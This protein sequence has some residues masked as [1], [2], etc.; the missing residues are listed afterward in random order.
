MTLENPYRAAGAFSGKAY[1][2]REA[3]AQLIEQI[4]DN[5]YYPYFA[6]PRQ[7]GKSSLLLRTMAALDP[8]KYRCALVDLSPFV[9]ASYDDFW[10]QFLHEVARSANFDPTPI[11]QEDPRDVLLLWLHG[12]KQ[13]LI[14][15]MD[16]IDVL[17]NVDFR[18]Q[19]FSKFRTFFNLR[20]RLDT[21]ELQ[22]L[23][24]VL[25]G[26]AHSSR[27][28]KDPRWSPFNVAIEIELEDLS[29]AQV[30]QLAAYLGTAGAFAGPDLTARVY[31]LSGGSVFL[32]QLIF[33]QLWNVAARTKGKLGA[34]DVDAV[35]QTIVAES[36]RNIHFYNIFRLVTADARLTMLFRRLTEGQE[37]GLEEAKELRLTGICRGANPFRNEIYARVFGPGGP[38]DLKVGDKQLQL[39][40]ALDGVL[41]RRDRLQNDP[42]ADPRALAAAEAEIRRLR[43]EFREGTQLQAGDVL[44]RGRYRLEERIGQGGFAAVWRAI[45]LRD[46][47]DP[48]PV[49]IK[50]LHGQFAEDKSRRERFFRGAWKMS[51]LQHPAIVRVIEPY[52]DENGQFYFV[53]EYLPGG[54]LH[55]AVQEMQ[56]A[57][58]Q[59][60]KM[61]VQVGRALQ[62]AHERGL[63]HRDV[64]PSNVMVDGDQGKLTDFDLV[65]ETDITGGTRTGAMGTFLYAAPEV[66][67]R[68]Q[69]ADVRADVYGLG[70]TAVF[71]LFGGDLAMDVIRDA[72]RFIDRLPC[73]PVIQDVLKKAVAWDRNDR[74]ASAAEFVVALELASE[75]GAGPVRARVQVPSGAKAMAVSASRGVVAAAGGAAA[76]SASRGL[77]A[78][79]PGATLAAASAARPAA[80]ANVARPV[81][82]LTGAS[83]AGPVV[84]AAGGVPVA[85]PAVSVAGPMRGAQDVGS[86]RATAAYGALVGEEVVDV[87]DEFA[88]DDG[89][90]APVPG[91]TIAAERTETRM[92]REALAQAEAAQPIAG[93][94]LVRS[95]AGVPADR[96]HETSSGPRRGEPTVSALPLATERS[97][98]WRV[99]VALLA[100]AAV[101][102]LFMI[103]G[104]FGPDA[105]PLL[106]MEG[107]REG[108]SAVV[109]SPTAPEKKDTPTPPVPEPTRAASDALEDGDVGPVDASAGVP[110]TDTTTGMELAPTTLAPPTSVGE[111]GI[112]PVNNDTGGKTS[113]P[114][115]RPP[116]PRVSAA[117]QVDEGCKQVSGGDAEKG[118]AEL[119]KAHDRIPGDMRLLL[120]LGDGYGKLGRYDSAAIFYDRLLDRW[121]RHVK[122]LLGAAQANEGLNRRDKAGEY[123]RRLLEINPNNASAAAFFREQAQVGAALPK[124]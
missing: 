18:E 4:E 23:Q 77:A 48:S 39:T 92:M 107:G 16:E 114:G 25:A 55:A 94:V 60:L 14:V 64:K 108:S 35:V 104:L 21:A 66:M 99:P 38:L 57:P 69:D 73:N 54:T 45:D 118:V 24:F 33:E 47:N 106:T 121:P 13:R 22:R 87:D 70:M 74:F 109:P 82:A 85:A 61:I 37:L 81:A 12:C 40:R 71:A 101:L 122:G 6:A 50:V 7:S 79:A 93:P 119:L 96:R 68:P 31:D 124:R 111:V 15:F 10:R 32:C 28:I 19:I 90:E 76:A 43:K 46:P 98:N 67:S 17:L 103:P 42:Q 84:A 44:G 51:E 36:P 80:A 89:A 91:R 105:G 102:L 5:Q 72:D 65:R 1:I 52:G 49:A 78:P 2:R 9:V 117:D 83:V 56:V 75:E 20:A 41:G 63:V 120:C 30:S 110:L 62:F 59:A 3:D 95:F 113:D 86:S 123:Y 88:A 27:F 8:K 34:A 58:A 100:V 97:G 116:T 112:K 11:G 53:M 26:A 115:D 29:A